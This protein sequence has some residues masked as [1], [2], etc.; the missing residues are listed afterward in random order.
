MPVRTPVMFKFLVF[1]ILLAAG[2]GQCLIFAAPISGGYP[3]APKATAAEARQL[4][5]DAGKK[6]EGVP[7]VY[8]GMSNRGVDCSGF[9]CLSFNDALGVSLPRSAAGLYSWAEK[10]SVDKAQPGDLV[11]FRTGTTKDVTHVGLYLGNRSFIHAA[12]AG[13]KTGVI[14]SS[15]DEKYYIDTFVSAGRALSAASG[16]SGGGGSGKDKNSE[17][18]D[19]TPRRVDLLIGAG[20]AVNWDFF[21]LSGNIIRG[22][23]S[24]VSFGF[25]FNKLLSFGVEVRPEYD[26]ALDV[27]RLPITLSWG[28]GKRIRIFAGPVF[29][30][31]EPSFTY[32][33]EYMTFSGGTSWFGAAGI[34]FTPFPINISKQE[35]APY[36]EAAWQAYFNNNP[37]SSLI[38]DILASTRIS[39]GLRWRMHL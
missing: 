28:P 3:S 7:Y 8:A 36:I 38:A 21:R 22:F 33:D 23:S 12:S 11:F 18:K 2:I 34:T 39:T 26:D 24:Q 27:F 4:V 17:K 32:K 35:L 37:N 30:F 5:I 31:G 29:S 19:D 16:S 20:G 1:F 15:L 13:S 10:I 9:I 6:Y 14:Y 25:S